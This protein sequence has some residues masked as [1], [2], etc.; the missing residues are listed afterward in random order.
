MR[1]AMIALMAFCLGLPIGAQ[2]LKQGAKKE[3][4]PDVPP[5]ITEIGGKNI[6]QWIKDIQASDPSRREVAIRT[7]LMFGPQKSYA[8]VPELLKELKKHTPNTPIDMNTRMNGATALAEALNGVKEPDPKYVKDAVAIMRRFLKDPQ[9]PVKM[10]ALQALPRLG[11]A[12]QS[13]LPE[14]ILLVRDPDTW[15][16]RQAAVQTL[17]VLAADPKKLPDGKVLYALYG[18][19]NSPW[20]LHDSS[21]QVRLAAVQALAVLGVPGEMAQKSYLIHELEKVAAKDPEPLVQIYAHLALMTVK[22]AISYDQVAPIA[23]LL[24][25]RD[26]MVRRQAAAALGMAGALLQSKDKKERD[27]A[28]AALGLGSVKG[29]NVASALINAL[30]D[31]DPGVVTTCIGALVSMNYHT[32]AALTPIAGLLKHK[33]AAV[34]AQAAQALALAG[35][36]ARGA[37]SLLIAG[38]DDPNPAVVGI[39]MNALVQMK[40]SGAE[41]SP[42]AKMLKHS[43]ALLRA[44]AAQALGQAGSEGSAVAPALIEALDDRDPGVVEACVIALA[45]LKYNGA[46]PALH[47]LAA[48][49]RQSEYLRKL[50]LNAVELIQKGVTK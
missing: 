37:A 2:E 45:Q 9:A 19:I 17:M 46:V 26:V 3:A 7:V 14:V 50:A 40:L 23:K 32:E 20:G 10:R 28:A 24:T 30:D 6:E 31:P 36:K 12:A 34:R 15:E 18:S 33:D 8:A 42:V 16:T 49:L 35:P 29:L 38:L 48:D 4:K 25:H 22:K 13:A 47:R 21:N 27:Q 5:P 11:A 1:Y 39:S 43:S 41:L 44:Q